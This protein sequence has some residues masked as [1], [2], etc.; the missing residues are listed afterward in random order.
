MYGQKLLGNRGVD[1]G[2]QVNLDAEQF[3][4]F[5][6]TPTSML[7]NT[8]NIL[9]TP[10]AKNDPVGLSMKNGPGTNLSS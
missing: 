10:S 1:R 3:S 2:T 7:V 9:Q 4:Q 8:T 6:G 5:Q